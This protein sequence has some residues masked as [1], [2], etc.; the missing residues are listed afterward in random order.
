[1]IEKPIT[2]SLEEGEN[3]L[4]AL[5]RGLIVGVGHIERF[6]PIVN[7]IKK[8]ANHI[9]YCEIRRHN[10]ASTRITDATVVKDLMIHDIDIV[11]NVLFRG[12]EHTFV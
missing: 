10:P 2:L 8:V 4:D 9:R 7:E 12:K 1:M 11:F 3:L 6:N 5:P